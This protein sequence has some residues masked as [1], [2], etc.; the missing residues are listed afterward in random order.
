MG[1]EH[2]KRAEKT[3]PE[4][5]PL[6]QFVQSVEAFQETIGQLTGRYRD[7]EERYLEINRQLEST[8]RQL[9]IAAEENRRF[10]E[11]L[12]RILRSIDVGIV[13]IDENGIVRFFN[14]AAEK[15]LGQPGRRVIGSVFYEVFPEIREKLAEESAKRTFCE[16]RHAS[17]E[18]GKTLELSVNVFSIPGD[19]GIIGAIYLIR[20]LT[21]VRATEQELSR[22]K[23][24]AALGEMSATLAHEIKNPL[25]GIA[26][27][28]G[29]LLRQPGDGPQKKWAKKIEE[30][31]NRLDSL[32][33]NMLEFARTPHLQR[34]PIHWQAFCEEISNAFENGLLKR[35]ITLVRTFPERWPESTGD[36]S[37][38]RQVVL[39]LLHNAEQ[40][41]SDGGEIGLHL[42]AA[43]E[44]NISLDVV[45]N[46]P[47]M[48]PETIE[49]IF[50]PFFT[51]R[52][53][54]TGL[55]LA[56]ARKIVEA[57]GGSIQAQSKP[58][59][60]SRFKIILPERR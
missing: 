8:N 55:G 9:Q 4:G 53:Q 2:T 56:I 18:A 15:L 14:P 25:T 60:G 3:P 44:G 39:N 7:L 1:Q 32:I 5:E 10:G 21:A 50:Q 43:D 27:Y 19:R 22:L 13:A 58:G 31:V 20:D 16:I 41:V 17:G 34:R 11:Y 47:G 45:D 40:A 42:T 46:G 48:N 54:G 23:T 28:C 26:G 52:E 35:R 29:L 36:A 38:L 51:T 49:Q 37:L 59:R 57:H 12:D 24:L 6:E 30:G 33:M